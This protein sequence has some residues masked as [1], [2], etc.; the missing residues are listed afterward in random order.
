VL[1]TSARLLRLLSL[2]QSRRDWSGTDLADRLE[3]DVRTVRRDVDR[4]RQLG[5]PV[6]SVSG[7]AGGYRLGAGARLPPLLLDDDEAVAVAVA[8][9]TA[10]EGVAGIQDASARALAKLDQVL[11][12]RLQGRLRAVGSA[13]VRVPHD[14]A[15]PAVDPSALA[16][17]AAACRDRVHLRFDY[18]AHDG[19]ESSRLVEPHRLVTWGPRW[20]LLA[21]DLDR[22]AWRTFRLDRIGVRATGDPFE[23]RPL[24]EGDAAAYVAR[25]ASSAAWRWRARVEV[26]APAE[27]VVA[28]VNP[29]VG[30][31]EAVGAT[32]CV[33]ST[34]AES[35]DELA[36]HLG[37][38][39]VGFRVTEPPELVAHLRGLAALYAAATP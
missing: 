33:L 29:A 36:A 13:T 17:V 8:L 21:W 20:Y 32:S 37:R 1:E 19:T 34:G 23:P 7:P 39:G 28:K 4:L 35:L 6:H 12:P 10:P 3:V 9:R 2:L 27:V 15:V 38:L 24:P 22:D 18:A 25:G 26:A 31:V 16:R 14:K 30:V 11:P 5:Y